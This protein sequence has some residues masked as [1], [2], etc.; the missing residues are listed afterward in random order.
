MIKKVLNFKG[1]AF[2]LVQSLADYVLFIDFGFFVSSKDGS[3]VK[4]HKIVLKVVSFEE[5]VKKPD[6]K[7]RIRTFCIWN[8]IKKQLKI[9]F[10]LIKI[11]S[12]HEWNYVFASFYVSAV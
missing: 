8:I 9:E 6:V 7:H 12:F 2:R 11:L 3:K 4:I 1:F 5:F 10:F